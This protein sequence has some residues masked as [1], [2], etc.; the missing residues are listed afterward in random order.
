[1]YLS[2]YILWKE[3]EICINIHSP[4][5]IYKWCYTTYNSAPCFLHSTISKDYSNYLNCSLHNSGAQGSNLKTAKQS[6]KF[7]IPHRQFQTSII[8]GNSCP[9]LLYFLFISNSPTLWSNQ[10]SLLLP[11]V[12]LQAPACTTPSAC[13]IP[14]L[15]LKV[16]ISP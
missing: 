2:K 4:S 6:L 1:M 11:H 3:K 14:N 7:S 9:M 13:S 16:H 15:L 12:A 8:H 5:P 10:G